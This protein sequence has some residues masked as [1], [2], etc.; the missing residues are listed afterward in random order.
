MSEASF[1]IGAPGVDTDRIVSAVRAR[2]EEK[3]KSGMYRDP[4]IGRAELMNLEHI[5]NEEGFLAFYLEC[6]REAVFVDI[7]DFRIVERR[8][9]FAGLLVGLKTVIWKLLKF[10]T[11]RLWS[12]QNQV[13]G[14]LLA[15]IETSESKSEQH[16][17]RLEAR[18]Q[19]L[20]S[21]RTSTNAP[22]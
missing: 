22:V 15:A 7:S 20:E 11:Y 2:V 13:N 9:R 8:A 3:K 16:L 18:I 5:K 1:E 6:L 14:L 10:Y 4:R 19:A 12:Q 21:E 17:K